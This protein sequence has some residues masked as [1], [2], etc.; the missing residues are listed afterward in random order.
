MVS[1]DLFD[2]PVLE[3]SP[4]VVKT[5]KGCIKVGRIYWAFRGELVRSEKKQIAA[6]FRW[7]QSHTELVPRCGTWR[8]FPQARKHRFLCPWV[9]DPKPNPLYMESVT[10]AKMGGVESLKPK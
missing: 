10:D 6:V 3:Y 8:I 4:S 5:D 1:L 9:G 2:S 7:I